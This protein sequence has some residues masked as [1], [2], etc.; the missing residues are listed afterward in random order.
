MRINHNI[1]AMGTYNQLTQAENAQGKSM[2]QLSTGKRINRGADDAAGLAIS[3]R[4]KAQI[5]GLDQASRN[6]QDGVSMIQVADGAMGQATDILQ[7]MKELATQAANDTNG[8]SDRTAISGEIQS[9]TSGLKDIVANTTF[10]GQ[11]LLG[12][13][14]TAVKIQTGSESG[15]NLTL[16]FN[17]KANLSGIVSGMVGS[18]ITVGTAGAAAT[19]ISSI[20]NAIDKVSASRAYLGAS[21][22]RL[23]HTITNLDTASQNTQ[24][25]QSRI[26]DV[27]MAK[28]VMENSKNGILAQAG[29]AMLGQANQ[30]PQ[31]VLQLLRG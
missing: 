12:S 3:E 29:Q 24:A 7:R 28:A 31:G 16:S 27:D 17:T 8:A 18:G 10:N 15:Q 6:S 22:D 4:M 20:E 5:R 11:K 26:E 21:Q 14:S 9:L 1:T 19:A 25:A 13:G 23:E 30:M 2:E